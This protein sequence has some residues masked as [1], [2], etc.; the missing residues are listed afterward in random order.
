MMAGFG[1]VK[2]IEECGE[3]SQIAAKKLAFPDTDDH[4][5]SMGSLKIR[6]EDE[7]ADVAA[8]AA[9]VIDHFDLDINRM[10]VRRMEKL[11]KFKK[12]G[13]P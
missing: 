11:G 10:R 1:L 6:L 8:A 13:T 2:L 12:W 5:D 9:Y 4:P 7:L 3:L